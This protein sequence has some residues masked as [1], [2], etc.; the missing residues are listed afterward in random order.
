MEPAVS[1]SLAQEEE[2]VMPDAFAA[3]LDCFLPNV[4][5]AFEVWGLVK[6]TAH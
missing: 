3:V 5:Q 4:V 1:M 2:G 6:E